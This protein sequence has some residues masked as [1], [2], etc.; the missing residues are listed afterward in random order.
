MNAVLVRVGQFLVALAWL[1]TV[2][3]LLPTQGLAL[4]ALTLFLPPVFLLTSFATPVT[5]PVWV[6]FL[7]GVAAAV[8]GDSRARPTVQS[9]VTRAPRPATSGARFKPA[10][11]VLSK[12]AVSVTVSARVW[13]KLEALL[14]HPLNGA[15]QFHMHEDGSWAWKRPASAFFGDSDDLLARGGGSPW[16]LAPVVGSLWIKLDSNFFADVADADSASAHV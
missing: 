10:V 16:R 11:R 12:P 3:D 15:G 8:F 4:A 9:R 2:V 7:V 1:L 6:L 14:S 5:L 13:T